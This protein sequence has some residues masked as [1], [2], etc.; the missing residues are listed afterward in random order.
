MSPTPA[1]LWAFR[2]V[3][4]AG[5]VAIVAFARSG[6]RPFM[7]AA[8]SGLFLAIYMVQAFGEVAVREAKPPAL[9]RVS[10][11]MN[12]PH[13]LKLRVAIF[14]CTLL[15]VAYGMSASE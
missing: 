13:G 8:I 11:A 14:V 4:V 12:G 5:V 10:N 2:L 15:L 1:A 7:L 6:Q 3:V 9:D